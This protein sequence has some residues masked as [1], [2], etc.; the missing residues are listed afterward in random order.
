[1]YKVFEYPFGYLIYSAYNNKVSEISE[2]MYNFLINPNSIK[3]NFIEE[4]YSYLEKN[5]F[6]KNLNNLETLKN[7]LSENNIENFLS[8]KLSHLILQVSKDCNLRCK[9]CTF[10][11]NNA[12]QKTHEKKNMSYEVAMKSIKIFPKIQSIRNRNFKN[13]KM[14]INN[15]KFIINKYGEIK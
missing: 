1:M 5:E 8:G 14:N 11:R 3:K 9:Y 15:I 2:E 6:F 13:K 12:N 4:E 7:H 10:T